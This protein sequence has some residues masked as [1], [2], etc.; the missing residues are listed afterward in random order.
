MTALH[1]AAMCGH[2]DIVSALLRHGADRSVTDE[3]GNTAK[4]VA[5]TA[6]IKALL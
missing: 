3:D 6:E 5:D 1:Y 2:A 4:Q